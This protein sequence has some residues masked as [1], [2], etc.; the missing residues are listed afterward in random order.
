M[1]AAVSFAG[2]LYVS[3]DPLGGAATWR[4][5]D[6]D[7][8]SLDTHLTGISC[9]EAGFCVAVAAGLPS[10]GDGG[11]IIAIRDP[12]AAAPSL[13]VT[14]LG[15]SLQLRSV[16]CPSTSFCL[17]VADGGRA[18]SSVN[19]GAASPVW[20]EVGVP[21]PGDL[22]AVACPD[23]SLCLAGNSG[24]NILSGSGS[25]A[26]PAGWSVASTG[27]S[28]QI[29]G[30]SC[31]S[32][33]LCAASDNNG[34]AIVSAAPSGPTGSWSAT[35]LIPYPADA[36]GRPNN[37]LFGISCPS[38][39][40]CAAVG[41]TGLIFTSANPFDGG[42]AEGGGRRGRGSK[43][44]RMKIIRGDSFRRQSGTHGAGSRVTFRLRPFSRVRGF[45]CSIDHRRFHRCRTPLRIYAKVGR[46][47]VRACAIGST[48]L[49][50]PVV[51]VRFEVRRLPEDRRAR[52]GSDPR[53]RFRA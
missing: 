34:D 25:L 27:V 10:T 40:F 31:P 9:P 7:G 35:N 50:G 8:D 53:L 29:T 12:L 36:G 6:L 49:K 17:A 1:C 46:H 4:A 51:R 38:A 23:P 47:V 20:R 18:A 21:A 39:R 24:G 30:I 52:R 45:V 5:T 37:A 14:Q 43:R 16:S 26:G 13:T 28:V 42:K 19:P 41:S 2:D 3:R 15:S 33:S 11:T 44:P 48:G 32:R 22:E